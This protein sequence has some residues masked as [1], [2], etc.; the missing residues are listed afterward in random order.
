MALDASPGTRRYAD[1]SALA[2]DL[3][4]IERA[5]QLVLDN[6]RAAEV[7][8]A[9]ANGAAKPSPQQQAE[10]A[11]PSPKAERVADLSATMACP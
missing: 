9:E 1:A 5:V 6:D 4:Q 8:H 11:G 7:A 10:R 2:S 3:Q